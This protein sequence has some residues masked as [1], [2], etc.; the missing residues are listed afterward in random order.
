MT[1][2][3]NVLTDAITALVTP[4]LVALEVLGHLSRY[5][6]P[7]HLV[8]L[9]EAA[10]GRDDALRRGLEAFRA[11][12]WPDRPHHFEANLQSAAESVCRTFDALRACT[13]EPD[14]VFQAYR[15][16]RT[17]IRAIEALYPA[18]P[19][20]EPV[21]RFFL[22]PGFRDDQAL[23]RKIAA[24]DSGRVGV[25]LEHR[26][27]APGARGGYALY[28][29]EY[30]D[31]LTTMPSI[32]AL[33]GGSGNGADFLWTWLAE[34]RSRGAILISP[35]ARG[36]TWSLMGPDI[37]SENLDRIVGEVGEGWNLDPD[38]MLLTGMSDGGT[39]AYL[40]GLRDEARFTHLA[41]CSASFHPMLLEGFSGERLAGLPIYLIHGALDWMFPVHVA[42]TAERALRGA[43]ARVE[44]REIADLS[45]TY[46]RDENPRVMDWFLD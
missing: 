6:H 31:A 26:G 39:F 7:P 13:E 44:Y 45:H 1:E 35:T 29:P 9:V 24:A 22:E 23:L 11:V 18:W 2:H 16:L 3:D 33:H 40:C 17:R 42:H 5:L 10:A 15:A 38:K 36:N 8:A 14:G 27:G 20:L 19:Q 32:V 46:P 37:D 25:G 12:D 4:M 41:P 30:Y 28:V 43:G 21:N 34:A